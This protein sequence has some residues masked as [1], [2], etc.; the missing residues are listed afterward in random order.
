[1]RRL[2]TAVPLILPSSKLS[3]FAVSNNT[4]SNNGENPLPLTQFSAALRKDLREALSL[5]PR[6]MRQ[7]SEKSSWGF[8]FP[9][10]RLQLF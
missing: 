10:M 9:S 1:M 3:R 4:L 5:L 8:L 6:T 7:L 2:S